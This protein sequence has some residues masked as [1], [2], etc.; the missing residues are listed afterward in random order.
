MAA[1]E[2]AAAK[3]GALEMKLARLEGAAS[4]GQGANG[5]S[6]TAEVFDSEAATAA[7]TDLENELSSKGKFK[8]AAD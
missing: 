5:A 3:V 2:A 4:A 8:V 6:G 7:I 1:A